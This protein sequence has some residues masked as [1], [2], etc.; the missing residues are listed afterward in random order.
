M[1]CVKC[2]LLYRAFLRCLLIQFTIDLTETGQREVSSLNLSH[3]KANSEEFYH[4]THA[5]PLA[6]NVQRITESRLG[7]KNPFDKWMFTINHMWLKGQNYFSLRRKPD[8]LTEAHERCKNGAKMF[9][10]YLRDICWRNCRVLNPDNLWGGRKWQRFRRDKNQTIWKQTAPWVSSCCSCDQNRKRTS[11]LLRL[12]RSLSSTKEVY[13]VFPSQPPVPIAESRQVTGRDI[14]SVGSAD[15]VISRNKSAQVIPTYTLPVIQLVP[16]RAVLITPSNLVPNTDPERIYDEHTFESYNFHVIQA[17]CGVFQTSTSA[18]AGEMREWTVNDLFSGKQV[19]NQQVRYVGT[20]LQPEQADKIFEDLVHLTCIRTSNK[21]DSV[22]LV[23]PI[24]FERISITLERNEKAVLNLYQSGAGST[25]PSLFEGSRLRR[26]DSRLLSASVHPPE[27][28]SHIY[29]TVLSAPQHG[30][31]FLKQLD[32]NIENQSSRRTYLGVN[33]QFTQ[34]DINS[35]RLF[36]IFRRVP[37]DNSI[38]EKFKNFKDGFE[39]RLQVPGAQRKEPSYFSVIVNT[40]PTANLTGTWRMGDVKVVNKGGEVSEGGNLVITSK[41]LSLEPKT[42]PE[43]ADAL[44]F[45]ITTFPKHGTLKQLGKDKQSSYQIERFV[46]YLYDMFEQNRLMYV[47][48]GSEFFQD[49]FH[50]QLVCAESTLDEQFQDGRTSLAKFMGE[51]AS[52]PIDGTFRLVINAV[53]DNPPTILAKNV[54][55]RFNSTTVM[56]TRWLKV[57]DYDLP[58]SSTFPTHYSIKWTILHHYH[59]PNIRYPKCG[60]FVNVKSGHKL[61]NFTMHAV[62]QSEIAFRNQGAPL[63]SIMLTVNDGLFTSNV[64]VLLNASRPIFQVFGSPIEITKRK[65]S[66]YPLFFEILTNIEVAPNAIHV[67]LHTD[68]CYGSLT[69]ENSTT[70]LDSFTYADILDYNIYFRVTWRYVLINQ[71]LED[72]CIFHSKRSSGMKIA[73][74]QDFIILLVTMSFGNERW[75]EK[76]QI[77][78]FLDSSVGAYSL[79]S[80]GETQ[81]VVEFNTNFNMELGEQTALS[82]RESGNQDILFGCKEGMFQLRKAPVFGELVLIT[83]SFQ[84][85]GIKRFTLMDVLAKRIVYRLPLE[86]PQQPKNKSDLNPFAVECF[87]IWWINAQTGCL[88]H[89]SNSVHW[90][91]DLARSQQI[92]TQIHYPGLK[93]KVRDITMEQ[94]GH[95]SLSDAS[96]AP[97]SY[98]DV[99]IRHDQPIFPANS[100]SLTNEQSLTPYVWSREQYNAEEYQERIN[101][102]TPRLVYL[103]VTC[104]RNGVVISKRL[105]QTVQVLSSADLMDNDIYYV[106]HERRDSLEDIIE[107]LAV[108]TT[109]RKVTNHPITVKVNI[110]PKSV[111]HLAQNEPTPMLLG[112][113]VWISSKYLQA[114]YLGVVAGEGVH[115]QLVRVFGGYLVNTQRQDVP[116]WSFTQ[117]EIDQNKILFVN[118][119]DNRN[120][121]FGFDFRLSLHSEITRIYSH[122]FVVYSAALQLVNNRPLLAFALGYE[123]ITAWHLLHKVDGLVRK[124]ARPECGVQ[125]DIDRNTATTIGKCEHLP[126]VITYTIVSFPMHGRLV[127]VQEA[128]ASTRSDTYDPP[129]AQ[130]FTQ[131]EIN[132]NLIAYTLRTTTPINFSQNIEDRVVLRVTLSTPNSPPQIAKQPLS[133]SQ[134]T[135]LISLIINASLLHITPQNQIRLVDITPLVLEEGQAK[136]IKP[137]TLDLSPIKLLRQQASARGLQLPRLTNANYWIC[138]PPTHGLL[139]SNSRIV[140]SRDLFSNSLLN[141]S[142]AALLYKHDGSDTTSDFVLF[143]VR[144]D[145]MPYTEND[146]CIK[147][148]IYILPV[149]NKHPRIIRPLL[150]SLPP[151][152]DIM[153]RKYWDIA[154]PLLAGTRFQLS[155][156]NIE[157]AD[158]DTKS[159]DLILHAIMQPQR[160][161]LCIRHASDSIEL[162]AN[163]TKIDSSMENCRRCENPCTFRQSQVESGLVYYQADDKRLSHILLDSFSFMVQEAK[164]NVNKMDPPVGT[165]LF[166][167]VPAELAV[168]ITDVLL[169]QGQS[170]VSITNQHIK[171]SLVAAGEITH[172][173]NKNASNTFLYSIHRAPLYGRICFD[174]VPV[175]RFTDQQLA[176]GHLAYEQVNQSGTSDSLILIVSLGNFLESDKNT[177][178]LFAKGTPDMSVHNPSDAIVNADLKVYAVAELRVRV[179]PLI[180]TNV[181]QL[182]PG[183]ITLINSSIIQTDELWEFINQKNQIET[184]FPTT[185]IPTLTLPTAPYSKLGRFRIRDQLFVNSGHPD[186]LLMPTVNITLETVEMNAVQF[187]AYANEFTQ[188]GLEEILPY[189]LTIGP[190]VQ[191]ASGSLRLRIVRGTQVDV[192][193]SQKVK[194]SVGS[195]DAA[196]TNSGSS[197]WEITISTAVIGSAVGFSLVS[198]GLFTAFVFCIYRRRQHDHT[199]VKT[200]RTHQPATK[201]ICQRCPS[202]NRWSSIELTDTDHPSV[203]AETFGQNKNCPQGNDTVGEEPQSRLS[204]IPDSSDAVSPCH[205]DFSGAVIYLAPATPNSMQLVTTPIQNCRIFDSNNPNYFVLPETYEESSQAFQH[206]SISKLKSISSSTHTS[207]HNTSRIGLQVG[208]YQCPCER[209]EDKYNVNHNVNSSSCEQKLTPDKDIPYVIQMPAGTMTMASVKA[210]PVWIT[211]AEKRTL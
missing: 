192:P 118:T 119:D 128:Q 36:Y 27:R 34:Q 169:L 195:L 14:H 85:S 138:R 148:P 203:S 107:L 179:K 97:L 177:L 206:S 35:G 111:L 67:Y 3:R 32:I 146:P 173:S 211:S 6:Y 80:G 40:I 90:R 166:R 13:P 19:L 196:K 112:C 168:D 71:T 77:F 53:N 191:P 51:F 147:Y 89:S 56:P 158:E 156:S 45:R 198:L 178:L 199:S 125:N 64:P 86:Q 24:V 105:N 103:I 165:V 209:L 129:N 106:H 149:N 157:I 135:R 164:P 152:T 193:G 83:P 49:E 140:E 150:T 104:P 82:F 99:P 70:P 52:Q 141:G 185:Y 9:S 144:F 22:R 38:R 134:E 109:E 181:I 55:F 63:C 10:E 139:Q 94:E 205:C 92:C 116:L 75:Q 210:F 145:R 187:E 124:T 74:Q 133:C 131:D 42:C 54:M 100:D 186:E 48:D 59:R 167:V 43:Y 93:L 162:F 143:Q 98:D 197:S 17:T 12:R 84:K 1:A 69:T 126:I 39:F 66:R 79:S 183:Q 26:I 29:Y 174:T 72:P 117:T 96:L 5:P 159:Q 130:T 62:Q 37:D 33:S 204:I 110:K 21:S 41:H 8:N 163:P 180:D 101:H 30:H 171:A 23:L 25:R 78:I 208:D 207:S 31:L 61:T 176:S 58:L 44:Q 20:L 28:D 120:G 60:Y 57:N 102:E 189:T 46:F 170:R 50:F 88:Q 182:T 201:I 155:K 108:D 87:E 123:I 151:F 114:Q 154:I 127:K 160:G 113:A 137:T 132:R 172:I 15:S 73:N 153:V 194:M 121:T 122:Q 7:L 136:E 142:S 18:P 81:R 76:V 115:F 200:H 47:H 161:F 91:P 11:K 188:Q 95:H 190:G 4:R 184:D 68:S 16:I 175:T 65:D 202:F 2:G